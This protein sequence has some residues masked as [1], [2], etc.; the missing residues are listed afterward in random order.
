MSYKRL[1][2]YKFQYFDPPE[3]SVFNDSAENGN[4][5]TIHPN[6]CEMENSTD[7][8]QEPSK[9][10]VSDKFGLTYPQKE[11]KKT[12]VFWL[13]VLWQ[14]IP[15]RGRS[16]TWHVD[17]SQKGE[18]KTALERRK[19]VRIVLERYWQPAGNSK[20]AQSS[21]VTAT[22]LSKL[23]TALGR[24]TSLLPI[25]VPKLIFDCSDNAFKERFLIF[26]GLLQGV[27]IYMWTHSVTCAYT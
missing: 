21:L 8:M 4:I 20:A 6:N 2:I 26:N 3:Q 5:K 9:A 23:N 24:L 15:A 18:R 10:H 22:I 7:S 13:S 17:G 1:L 12:L 27:V 19:D 25:R 16:C 14:W 11:K